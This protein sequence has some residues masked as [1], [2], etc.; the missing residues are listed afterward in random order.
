MNFRKR[1][2]L[3]S[4]LG[5]NTTSLNNRMPSFVRRKNKKL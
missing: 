1:M 3:I 5:L 4:C 2:R